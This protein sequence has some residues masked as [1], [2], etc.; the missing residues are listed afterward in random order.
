[1]ESCDYRKFR[2]TKFQINANKQTDVLFKFYQHM[3]HPC[4]ATWFVH[5]YIESAS[6]HFLQV[7]A[8]IIIQIKSL[9]LMGMSEGVRFNIVTAGLYGHNGM[10]TSFFEDQI[11]IAC[12]GWQLCTI[13]L[14]DLHFGTP[15]VIQLQLH[16]F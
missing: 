15:S 13:Q 8:L 1:M 12:S 11:E 10:M 14:E 7:Q 16:A 4:Y 5:K 6:F 2:N 3:V 9:M